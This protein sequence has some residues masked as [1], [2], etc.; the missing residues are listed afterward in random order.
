VYIYI[1]AITISEKRG[2][3]LG[4]DW[5]GVDGKVGKKVEKEGRM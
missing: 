5:G 1:Y 3:Q 4:G 2:H